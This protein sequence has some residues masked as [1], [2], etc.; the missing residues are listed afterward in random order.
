MVQIAKPETMELLALKNNAVLAKHIEDS[1]ESKAR[2]EFELRLEQNGPGKLICNLL[3]W[4]ICK[5]EE[6]GRKL[7]EEKRGLEDELKR[8]ERSNLKHLG[9][10]QRESNNTKILKRKIDGLEITNEKLQQQ[11]VD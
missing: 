6:K 9:N 10:S 3:R 1:V 4:L 8:L 7:A 5:E 2:V 11:V